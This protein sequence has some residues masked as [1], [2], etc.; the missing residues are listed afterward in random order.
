MAE[1]VFNRDFDPGYGRPVAVAP[2]VRRVT[3][4]NPSPLTFTGTNSYI[5]GSGRVAIIDPGPADS[6]HLDALM[7]ATRGETVSHILVTHAHR[8][9]ADAAPLLAQRTGA[10][11]YAHASAGMPGAAGQPAGG[12][13]QAGFIPDVALTDGAPV[14]GDTWRLETVATPGHTGDHLA[15]ALAGS[16][17]LFSGDHVM[18]WSTSVVI[19]P[20]GS[21]AQYLAS[22][23]K[24][25]EREEE[26]Y[27]P[28]HGGTIANAR[29]HALALKAHRLE[30]EAAV[31]DAVGAGASSIA[32]IV[33]RVYRGLD[34]Q[35][36]GA[37]A[38]SV[39]AHLQH[40]EA[41][42][43]VVAASGVYRL[44]PPR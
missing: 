20:D 1:L 10:T 40:L 24:M 22:L 5:V 2:G 43:K 17:V 11:V 37:A 31:L 19:P 6:A 32:S 14:S 7:A 8:D 9:H 28:G 34:P 30:R 26:T 18:G 21:M 3:A 12:E 13:A 23:D 39:L 33:E 16:D 41:Q 15:F 44:N 42:G 27:L 35:L 38:M 25:L 4:R 29:D 36:A